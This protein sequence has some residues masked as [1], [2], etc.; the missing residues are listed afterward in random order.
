MPDARKRQLQKL[1]ARRAAERQR[2]RRQR[3]I[4]GVVA[5]AVA[6]GG[7]GLAAAAFL[8]DG[9]EPQQRAR[10]T[11]QPG[12]TASP[13][14]KVACD[15]DVPK[16]EG[17][18]KPTFQK[19]PQMQ[20]DPKKDYR[21][22]MQTSCGTIELEL[23]AD[24]TPIT[25]NNFVFLAHEGFFDGLTFHRVIPGFVAQG[26]DPE[27][28]GAGGPGYQFEDEIVKSLTFDE[29]GLLAMANSGPN[30]NGSQFFITMG[31]AT[32]LDGLHTI[33]GRVAE[34][35]DAVK[36]IEALG[37]EGGTPSQ[38]IYIEKVTIEES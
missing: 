31:P 6:L 7:I 8:G 5:G 32:H 19:P 37:T 17:E 3:I 2:Q 27:G 14:S 4:A 21:A 13:K 38:T 9:E 34:G 1:A 28:T 35:T 29:P 16:A 22:T 12:P 11:P 24:Q 30:T 33:F 25:V 18:E 10:A 26:G 20:I 36:K 15:G 23:F